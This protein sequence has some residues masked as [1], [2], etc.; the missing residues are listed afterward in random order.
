[1]SNFGKPKVV[2]NQL[3]F[4]VAK[5]LEPSQTTPSGSSKLGFSLQ[6]TNWTSS[7]AVFPHKC[8]TSPTCLRD[9]QILQKVVPLLVKLISSIQMA[10]DTFALTLCELLK[11]HLGLRRRWLPPGS[12]LQTRNTIIFLPLWL[13]C[14]LCCW[15]AN[16]IGCIYGTF[17]Q[18]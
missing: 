8:S 2:L 13:C 15:I 3:P 5:R 10:P 16:V 11:I 18:N 12:L 7:A 14:C 9:G 4:R 6:L 17:I 1:M